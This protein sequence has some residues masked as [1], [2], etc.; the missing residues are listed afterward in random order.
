MKTIAVDLG[1]SSVKLGVVADGVLIDSAKI[2][3]RRGQEF[4]AVAPEIEV[5]C[6]KW[7]R[8]KGIDG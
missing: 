3:C 5:V 8:T 4:Q 6:K 7:Q 2:N 1:G